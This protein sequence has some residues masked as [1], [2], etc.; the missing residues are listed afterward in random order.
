MAEE[1]TLGAA[2]SRRRRTTSGIVR[3]ETALAKAEL[4]ADVPGMLPPAAGCSG[5]PSSCLPGTVP[6]L[7]AAAYGLVEA[8]L[9]AWLAFLI[10]A[11][12]PLLD[13]GV[14]V[15]LV[16][17]PV[18]GRAARAHHPQS[19]DH[20]G[21]RGIGSHSHDRSTPRGPP[22]RVP[23]GTGSWPANGARFHVAEAGEGPL[24]LLLHGF[25]SSWWCMAP[26]AARPGRRGVARVVAM[27]LR[28][29]GA[30]DKPPRGYDT[31]SLAADVA[32][33][34]RA[35][36][37]QTGG[38]RR[39]RLG[40]LDRLVDA[41]AAASVT[42]GRRGPRHGPPADPAGVPGR[43]PA[44]A[45]HRPAARLPGAR[46]AGAQVRRQTGRGRRPARLGGAR[47]AGPRQRWRSHTRAM[48]VPFVAH[49]S[50]EYYRWAVRSL[51]RSDGR[52]FAA[53]IRDPV[54][55]PVLQVHGGLDPGAP[56]RRRR[57]PAPGWRPRSGSNCCPRQVTTCRR[58][59]P[60]R[61]PRS[62]WTGSPR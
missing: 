27:D 4:Q 57:P 23:G 7:I 25:P 21:H 3:A 8:G 30:S 52:R 14:L 61:S 24:V 11:V 18:R 1:R 39:T 40:R 53:A 43:A 28:G 31:P 42:H 9:S 20:R 33:V 10:V 29:Y 49:T 56:G 5:P 19:P 6:L 16:G 36:G 59:L 60:S 17:R 35:L 62:C 13:R 22:R 58:R 54:T 50:M 47:P 34:V 41:R 32:G 45:G 46:D 51:W 37:A 55:V 12:V 44:A 48:Q 15:A 38:D 2:C 26:P